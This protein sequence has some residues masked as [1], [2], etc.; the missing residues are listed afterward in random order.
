MIK[1][2]ALPKGV[3]TKLLGD[4]KRVRT[5]VE[6]LKIQEF[7]M[8]QDLRLPKFDK[9]RHINQQKVFVFDSDNINMTSFWV[10]QN[11]CKPP[12]YVPYKCTYVPYSGT[13]GM[14]NQRLDTR[15]VR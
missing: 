7:I 10:V 15:H 13:F 8:M 4:T 6:C 3:I 11:C 5:L 9:N 1:R 14:S 2:S 12:R